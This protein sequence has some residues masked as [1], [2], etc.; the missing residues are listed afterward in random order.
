MR[1]RKLPFRLVY[2]VAVTQHLAPIA[3]KYH[4]LI[5]ETI[6]EHLRYEP[7]A[8]TRNRK[9]LIRPTE[10]GATWELRFGPKN[11]FRVFY[12]PDQRLHQVNIL[13]I[14]VKEGNI[15]SIGGEEYEL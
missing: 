6:Q 3:R 13:A 5:R 2:D 14:G 12:E 4:A 9:P 11:R 15:L 8:E 7:E 10:F 1:Q